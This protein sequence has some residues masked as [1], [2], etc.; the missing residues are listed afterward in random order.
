MIES[1]K[2]YIDPSNVFASGNLIPS[3]DPLENTESPA[4]N[5]KAKL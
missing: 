2:K 4:Q 1:V 5:I 3:S